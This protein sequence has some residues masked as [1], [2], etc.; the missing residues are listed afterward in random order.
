[1][2]N[3]IGYNLKEKF[4][5]EIEFIINGLYVKYLIKYKRDI[6]AETPKYYSEENIKIYFEEF[7]IFN[8]QGIELEDY[9]LNNFL[10]NN[11]RKQNLFSHEPSSDWE[12]YF[13][14]IRQNLI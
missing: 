11:F 12:F 7:R 8:L 4:E 6:L 13:D 2:R 9:E 5:T 10:E 14:K 3:F 1:M